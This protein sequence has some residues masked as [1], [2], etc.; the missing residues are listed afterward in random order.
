MGFRRSWCPAWVAHSRV[1]G[2]EPRENDDYDEY[3]DSR[4]SPSEC[5]CYDDWE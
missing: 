3:G 2:V 1:Y 4:Y 5:D